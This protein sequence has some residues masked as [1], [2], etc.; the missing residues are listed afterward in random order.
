MVRLRVGRTQVILMSSSS[1][2]M[3]PPYMSSD[4]ARRLQARGGV[5]DGP[6][7]RDSLTNDVCSPPEELV[8]QV[9]E[10][11]SKKKK[12][13]YIVTLDYQKASIY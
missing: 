1:P 13:I 4:F 6:V 10:V 11:I 2:Y 5:L 9:L 7:S 3:S 8:L 12:G